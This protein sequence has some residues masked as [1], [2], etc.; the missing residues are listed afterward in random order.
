MLLSKKARFLALS[1]APKGNMRGRPTKYKKTMGKQAYDILE[2]GGTFL[3]VCHK[4]DISE[5]TFFHWAGKG[6]TYEKSEYLKPEFSEYIKRGELASKVW[7]DNEIKNAA[8]GKGESKYSPTMLIFMTKMRGFIP[9]LIPELK[10]GT[11]IQKVD[12]ITDLY[13]DGII[14]LDT[15]N[16]AL[17]ALDRQTGI[18][19]KIK[20]E[21]LEA[22]VIKLE[23]EGVNVS[24]VPI[25]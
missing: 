4:L 3:D 22:R 16:L 15:Y 1:T 7:L 9:R 18:I 11:V 19:D 10:N 13:C 24:A 6:V 5:D 21:N 2:K 8:L 25:E 17:S 23:K 20:L 14:S 12:A